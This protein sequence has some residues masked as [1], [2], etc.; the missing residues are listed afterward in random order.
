MIGRLLFCFAL[1]LP[2][3][4]F[5]QTKKVIIPKYK[6]GELSYWYKWE[7]EKEKKLNLSDLDLAIDSAHFRLSIDNQILD[8]YSKDEKSFAGQ[9]IV[10]TSSYDQEQKKK[11]KSYS[12]TRAIASDTVQQVFELMM[13]LGINDIP[14]DDEI[15]EWRNGLDGKTYILQWSTRDSYSFKTY[16]MPELST[17]LAEGA[18]INAFVTQI[19]SLLEF[20]KTTESFFNQLPK[21]NCYRFG[22]MIGCVKNGKRRK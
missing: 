17:H 1:I 5:G 7:K 18:A 4:L 19:E 6:D 14:S 13:K 2:S 22:G 8:I 9:L 12:S 10:F 16:W 11:S 21:N 15:K 20:E 3:N